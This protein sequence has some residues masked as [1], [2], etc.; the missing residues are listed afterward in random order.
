MN[1]CRAL[2]DVNKVLHT[3]A[4]W[5]NLFFLPVAIAAFYKKLPLLGIGVLAVFVISMLYHT[6]PHT[7]IFKTA[8]I[9]LTN[10]VGIMFLIYMGIGIKKGQFKSNIIMK[11]AFILWSVSMLFFS[12]ATYFSDYKQGSDPHSGFLGPVLAAQRLEPTK[13]Y[14]RKVK[15]INMYLFFHTIWHILGGITAT[16]IVLSLGVHD[17][18]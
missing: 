11:V 10:S 12:L 7:P 1:E 3:W 4:V 17:T 13:D 15:D 2:K 6:I 9:L 16:L 8:D 18:Y 14:C 5:T